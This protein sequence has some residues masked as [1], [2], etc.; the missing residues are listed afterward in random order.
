MKK[1]NAFISYTHKSEMPLALALDA[2][3][4]KFAKPWNKLRALRIYRDTDSQGL[5]PNLLAA[6]EQAMAASEYLIL[7]ASPSAAGSPWVPR[8]IDYWVKSHPLD[9]L[10]IV[11]CEGEVIWD[12]ENGDFD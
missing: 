8:E 6:V 9:K 3:L 1:Y 7:L 4:T 10:L 12:E 2:A 11:V 5:T